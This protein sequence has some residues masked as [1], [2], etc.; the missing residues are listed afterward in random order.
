ML[1]NNS[2]Q[3]STASIKKHAAYADIIEAEILVFA[4]AHKGYGKAFQRLI[5]GIDVLLE[6]SYLECA[7]PTDQTSNEYLFYS[8]VR[9]LYYEIPSSFRSCISLTERGGYS[10]AFNCLRSVLEALVKHKF[11]LKNQDKILAYETDSKDASG[12]KV[13]IR[14]AFEES[15]GHDVQKAVYRLG[16][17]FEHKNFAAT[18]PLLR[19]RL[20]QENDYSLIPTF[21]K[22]LCEGVIN[23][24]M[25]LIFG[26]LNLAEHFFSLT[27]PI[28]LGNSYQRTK[29][30]LAKQILDRRSSFPNAIVWNSAMDKIVC[31][32]LSE[33][34]IAS[35]IS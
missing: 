7:I 5:E 3:T 24:L 31:I 6:I 22:H 19:A 13:T 9:H 25:Y 34:E 18:L 28:N 8:H 27:W 4:E 2:N 16:S 32:Q 1:T 11:L 26:Y 33:I 12:E 21:Q 10:D 23:H 20:N 17:Q 30:F 15:C 35:A 29:G 14:R